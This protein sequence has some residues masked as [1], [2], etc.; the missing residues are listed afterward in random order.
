MLSNLFELKASTASTFIIFC[1][2]VASI[3]VD[4]KENK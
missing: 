3:N 2:G 4:D 1:T